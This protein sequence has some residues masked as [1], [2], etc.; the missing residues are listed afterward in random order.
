MQQPRF[1]S[2]EPPKGLHKRNPNDFLFPHQ[3]LST[4]EWYFKGSSKTSSSIANRHNSEMRHKHEIYNK[5]QTCD[6]YDNIL[7]YLNNQ[8]IVLQETRTIQMPSNV[9]LYFLK[10]NRT[11]ISL[12]FRYAN[13][14]RGAGLHHPCPWQHHLTAT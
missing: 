12:R 10:Q 9:Y 13:T 4:M 3:V 2:T 11:H 14:C 5:K 8:H 7:I 1:D 6:Q